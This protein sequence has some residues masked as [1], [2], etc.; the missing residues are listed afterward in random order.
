M[1]DKVKQ[2]G[3][4]R[5]ILS[6]APSGLAGVFYWDSG[7]SKL[8]FHNGTSFAELADFAQL[9]SDTS[10]S[11]G[12]TK[13]KADN[14]SYSNISGLTTFTIQ[15]FLDRINVALGSAGGSAF[16]EASFR[17]FKTGAPSIAMLVSV[18]ALSAD[19]TLTMPDANVDLGALTNSNISASAAIAYS[20]LNLSGSIV[21][22]DVSAS[23]AI[24]YSKL[25]LS[26]SIVNADISSSA[27]IAYSKLNLA[28]S[29]VNADVATAA[30]IARSKL[31]SGTSNRL[32]VNDGSGVMADA[33]AITASRALVSDAN[34]I[35][36]HSSVT[37]TE[38]GYVSGV[39]SSIQ[40][41]LGSKIDS[42]EKGAN[43]GVATL[44]AGGKI[45]TSQ[46][47]NSVMEYKG[48]WD[49]SSNTPTLADGTGNA[50]DVYV[51]SVAGTQNLGSGSLTFAV[52]DWVMYNGSI[53]EKSASSNAVVSVNG[54]TGVVSLTTT[55]ISEGTNLYFTDER[56]QDAV[57]AMAANSSK[58]SLTYVDATPSL[59]AD[60]VAGS[61]V[62]A[63]INASAGIVYSKL[64]LTNGIVNADINSAAAIAYSKLSLSNSIVNADINTSAAIAY[65]KLSLTGSI[66]DADVSAS[67]AIAYSKLSLTGSIVNA[68]VSASAAIAY[69]K[70]SLTGSIIDADVSASA[71][72]AY[73]KL[74][75]SGSIVNADIASA[76]AIAMSKL[77]ALTTGRALQSNASTGFIEVSSVTNTELGYVS[78]VT[79]SIQS[80]LNGKLSSISQD[81][82]PTLGGDLDPNG[83]AIKNTVRFGATAAN[84]MEQD[85]LHAV[86][87]TASTTAVLASLTFDTTVYKSLFITYTCRNGNTRRTGTIMVS[88]D[89]VAT[90]ASSSAECFHDELDNGTVDLT[91]SV[92]MNGNN[93]EVS[94]T[95][96]AGTYVANLKV[97]RFKA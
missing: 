58:V 45:P 79:S 36:T 27:A 95:T 34:G 80:Q 21:N 86:S 64:S 37:A 93:C 97:E 49:A 18:A 38:L 59:T 47:P 44:D 29:I 48:T 72:I 53:W 41:Q 43:N 89:N 13:V 4:L 26:N 76:A 39:T 17:V 81:T 25:S 63:D 31:A 3:A 62:N 20:K 22:A 87:L 78:G 23:A 56:A 8:R 77:A 19:R 50:G 94:Y 57:G 61:L 69:S 5:P 67:A 16:D 88:A 68:D 60:I 92:A 12:A 74:N 71:A 84:S 14:K 35:P 33:A 91:W 51:V 24:A 28:A 54:Q 2:S 15:D 90:V 6:T 82:T 42:S 9:G 96:G 7:L 10:G 30:A 1:A 65:S 66:V 11:S 83:K 70:L 75:L 32:V 40:T 46:L 73:S 85:Y 52:L 55:N